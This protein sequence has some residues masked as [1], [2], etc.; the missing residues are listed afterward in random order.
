MTGLA[1]QRSAV[2][3]KAE[4]RDF[5]A[6]NSH[7]VASTAVAERYKL[8]SVKYILVSKLL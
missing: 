3:R 7:S 4:E 5:P 2:L 8:T 1:S 6:F